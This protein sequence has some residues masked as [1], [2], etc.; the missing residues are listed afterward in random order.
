MIFLIDKK[1]EYTMDE[2]YKNSLT[3]VYEIFKLMPVSILNKIPQKLKTI[4]ENE[5]NI[6]YKIIVKEPL[7]IEDFQYETIVFLGMIYRDF[8]C[9]DEERNEILEQEK[10][11][12]IQYEEELK[13]KYNVND[14]F[15]NK[16]SVNK[17]NIENQLMKVEDK[18]WYNKLF[19]LL[20]TILK[21]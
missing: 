13:I 4:I 1:Q 12:T 16:K 8:L 10:K 11:L 14:L 20:K 6:D 15:I 9:G 2:K 18:K 19:S 3:E 21:K 7:R 17:E 5:R